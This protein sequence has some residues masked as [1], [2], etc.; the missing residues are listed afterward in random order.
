MLR[1]PAHPIRGGA[2]TK[3]LSPFP[4]SLRQ[5]IIVASCEPPATRG[6]REFFRRSRCEKP[7]RR[8]SSLA[9]AL[10]ELAAI[11]KISPAAINNGV[12]GRASRVI[13]GA[14]E[15]DV[16]RRPLKNDLPSL[17]QVALILR[18]PVG[19]ARADIWTER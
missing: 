4:Q 16:G 15:M 1:P 3:A 12:F 18:P 2:F 19:P 6:P 11:F 13:V 5:E 7:T 8:V 17:L 14:D 9:P 10:P